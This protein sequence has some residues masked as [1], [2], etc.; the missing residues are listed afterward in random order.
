[1]T[2]VPFSA[3]N[4]TFTLSKG[5]NTTAYL[6]IRLKH[7]LFPQN[8]DAFISSTEF[9]TNSATHPQRVQVLPLNIRVTE[10]AKETFAPLTTLMEIY[11]QKNTVTNPTSVTLMADTTSALYGSP[12]LADPLCA[13][14]EWFISTTTT[15]TKITSADPL[16][17]KFNVA[18]TS[19]MGP[20]TINSQE[21]PSE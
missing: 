13:V 19:E 8:D 5:A 6:L 1:M 4:Y 20:L 14:K 11:V 7:C 21:A 12:S 10:C 9:T 15:T 18:M 3:G 16:Y 2:A 17:D